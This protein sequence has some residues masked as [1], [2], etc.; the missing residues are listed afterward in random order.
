MQ[1]QSVREPTRS[2]SA[3]ME[4]N[5]VQAVFDPAAM[6]SI[7]RETG[8][9]W[10]QT[11]CVCRETDTNHAHTRSNP[12]ETRTKPVRIEANRTTQNTKAWTNR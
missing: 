9:D 8:P 10:T 5:H 4:T 2:I 12:V 6:K 3:Q 11:E 1:T 7:C